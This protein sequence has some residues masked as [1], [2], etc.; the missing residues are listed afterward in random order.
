MASC[1]STILWAL[2]VSFSSLLVGCGTIIPRDDASPYNSDPELLEFPGE[3]VV[4]GVHSGPAAWRT[5]AAPTAAQTRIPV[6]GEACQR[7][8]GWPTGS[9]PAIGYSTLSGFIYESAF[10]SGKW[11]QGGL[12]D[13]VKVIEEKHKNIVALTDVKIDMHHRNILIYRE[14]CVRVSALAVTR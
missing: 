3:T 7:G 13:A 9:G 1:R 10:L 2:I 14:A 6:E 4:L 12:A 5:A 11:G 8:V